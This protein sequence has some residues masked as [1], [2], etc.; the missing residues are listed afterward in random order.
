MLFLGISGHVDLG[1]F[2]IGPDG[3]TLYVFA[4]DEPGLE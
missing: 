3:L 1:S 4:N 2:L